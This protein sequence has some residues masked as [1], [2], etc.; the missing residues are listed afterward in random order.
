MGEFKLNFAGFYKDRPLD[1]KDTDSSATWIKKKDDDGKLYDFFNSMS[2]TCECFANLNIGINS[3]AVKNN[4]TE[5]IIYPNCK[6]QFD[7]F[8]HVVKLQKITLINYQT[9]GDSNKSSINC[10][11]KNA[12]KKLTQIHFVK[13]IP[14]L[15]N[16]IFKDLR[17]KCTYE[18][19]GTTEDEALTPYSNKT[20]NLKD[21][22]NYGEGLFLNNNSVKIVQNI[23]EVIKPNQFKNCVSLTDITI[24]RP[25]TF[26]DSCFEGCSSLNLVIHQDAKGLGKSCFSG[27]GHI[28]F[29][30]TKCPNLFEYCGK[31]G[32]VDDGV[33]TDL[34]KQSD[35]PQSNKVEV[36]SKDDLDT[37]TDNYI[38]AGGKFNSKQQDILDDLMLRWDDSDQ[39]SDVQ[40][41]S[42]QT[43]TK[44]FLNTFL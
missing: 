31:Y 1:K 17:V 11:D 8:K 3:F 14:K 16:P 24:N 34:Y 5:V 13:H 21:L 30:S 35:A 28:S 27:I 18:Q 20:Y 4:I 44:A 36:N 2:D 25:T 19:I 29:D 38:Q 37:I 33:F 32:L 23:D 9:G 12:N 10:L 41:Q 7:C 15:T 42:L 6:L 26:G 40:L 22:G 39:L 43:D